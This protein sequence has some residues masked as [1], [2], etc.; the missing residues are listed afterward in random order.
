MYWRS[1]FRTWDD[2]IPAL[3]AG[4]E[5]FVP[6]AV[7][8]R[9]FLVEAFNKY[10]QGDHSD[11]SQAIKEQVKVML[12]YDVPEDDI[13]RLQLNLDVALLPNTVPA[14]F[15][16]LYN[17]FSR[18]ELL[19]QLRAELH[20]HAVS[21]NETSQDVRLD[22]AAVKTDCPRLLPSFRKPNDN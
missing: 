8:A 20:E 4:M 5:V 15:W 12:A 22:V 14:A 1:I 6:K 7:K 11:A 10:Q 2:G 19:H 17:A 16:T 9:H 13:A 21:R 18:P 3:M